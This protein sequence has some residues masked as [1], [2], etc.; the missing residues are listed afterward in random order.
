MQAISDVLPLVFIIKKIEFILK[1]QGD[2]LK[3]LCRI[4]EM[5]VTVHKDNQGV[6]ILAVALQIKPHMKHIPIKYHHFRGF[7][8]NGYVDIQHIDTKEEMSLSD[9]YTT[10]LMV[11][12]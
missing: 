4:L 3:V 9:I 6:I 2:T 12:R 8:A 5:K 11:G 1:L 10:R 7:D